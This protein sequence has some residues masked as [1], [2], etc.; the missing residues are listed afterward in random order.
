MAASD[1]TKTGWQPLAGGRRTG[2]SVFHVSPFTRLARTHA[3]AVAADTLIA[4]ALAGSLF[5]SISPTQA[6]ERVA[7]GLVLTMAPFSLVAPLIGPWLDRVR[8][9]RRWVVV[10][11]NALRAGICVL[12]IGH[13]DSLLLFP[14][15]FAVLVLSKAYSVAKSA[16]VPT[17]VQ[18]D[19]ELVESNSKLS[20]LSGV[21]GFVAAVPGLLANLVA[22]GQGV[23]VL[24]T[25]VFALAALF[26]TQIPPTR[27]APERADT[28]ERSE[29]RGAGIRLA[30]S[31]MGL[32]R[33]MVGFITFLIAFDLRRSDAPTW[34]FG[35]I[36]AS[37]GLGSMAGA[38]VAPALRKADVQEERII[39]LFLGVTAAMGLVAA[40][41]GQFPGALAMA[42]AVGIAA[43]GSKLAFDSIVGRDAPDANRGRSFARFETRFQLVWVLGALIPVVVPSRLEIPSRLGFLFVAGAA[44]FALAT[45]LAGVRAVAAGKPIP[46]RRNPAGRL[47][48]RGVDRLREKKLDGTRP[49]P[50]PRK[51]RKAKQ[52]REKDD[53]AATTPE[54]AAPAE[55][56]VPATVE[57]E[58][59]T[60]ALPPPP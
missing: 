45:Y 11:A 5:F 32:L 51:A 6:K 53:A 14:E 4:L 49:A 52:E 41:I 29:L 10:G 27:V 15:V 31:A 55:V 38:A 33:G 9:G 16:L 59:A 56:P 40:Y 3:A 35:V 12:M 21:M 48:R 46:E 18:S 34:Q 36:L 17:L 19:E 22:G 43:A 58:T 37:S 44:A 8:G 57:V 2:A 42:L 23:L 30:A 13:L 20:L 50:S 26:G 47:V 39:Q 25:G 60:A 28:I 7:L 24:A 1:D 54:A